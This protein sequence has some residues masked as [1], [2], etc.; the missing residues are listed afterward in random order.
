MATAMGRFSPHR[1]SASHR[2]TVLFGGVICTVS[3]AEQAYLRL[4]GEPA[5]RTGN[6]AVPSPRSQACSKAS[7]T[8]SHSSTPLSADSMSKPTCA[9]S[10]C[11]PTPAKE[12]DA[13]PI[14]G[15]NKL[16]FSSAMTDFFAT[17]LVAI[18]V[19]FTVLTV[20]FYQ[21]GFFHFLAKKSPEN[22][23]LKFLFGA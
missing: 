7:I 6:S 23:L 14:C 21:A 2:K 22:N 4:T 13:G 20:V 19:M 11:L 12:T 16:S 15:V 5:A 10:H 17:V 9:S 1:A 8:S 18:G 3:S